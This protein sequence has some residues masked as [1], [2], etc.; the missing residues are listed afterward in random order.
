[1]SE[2]NKWNDCLVS[3]FFPEVDEMLE[4]E[5][6][7]KLESLRKYVP[8]LI[9]MM[10]ELRAKT[11]REAQLNKIQSLHDMITNSNKKLKLET[12]NRC[13]EVLNNIYF[14]VNPQLRLKGLDSPQICPKMNSPKQDIPEIESPSSTP[15]SPSPPP[16]ILRTK[17]VTIPTEKV[18]NDST[19]ASSSFSLKTS[20]LPKVNVY[21]NVVLNN[22]TQLSKP[23]L[24]DMSKPPI[25]LD[26]LKTLEDDVHQKLHDASSE[27]APV[28]GSDTQRRSSLVVPQHSKEKKPISP[29]VRSPVKE[30]K[31][32]KPDKVIKESQ[33]LLGEILS[34][35]DEKILEEK[36]KKNNKQDKRHSIGD[37]KEEEPSSSKPES[38]CEKKDEADKSTVV[39]KRLADK[40]HPKPRQKPSTADADKKSATTFSEKETKAIHTQ[41][42]LENVNSLPNLLQN[43]VS[44]PIPDDPTLRTPNIVNAPLLKPFPEPPMLTSGLLQL[45]SPN[46]LLSSAQSPV[47]NP[48]PRPSPEMVFQPRMDMDFEPRRVDYDQINRFPAGQ[49][50]LP[51]A[52][53]HY[54]LDWGNSYY[55][56]N[57]VI[58]QK[59]YTERQWNESYNRRGLRPGDPRSYKEYKEMKEREARVSI[60]KSKETKDPRVSQRESKESAADTKNPVLSRESISRDPRLARY[61]G[62]SKE[63]YSKDTPA[64]E[65]KPKSTI[66]VSES[67][68]DKMYSST[69]KNKTSKINKK[70]EDAFISPLD[71]L[72]NVGREDKTGRGYGV[73]KFKIPK[74]RRNTKSAKPPLCITIDD[75][76]GEETENVVSTERGNDSDEENDGKEV[77]VSTPATKESKSNTNFDRIVVYVNENKTQSVKNIDDSWVRCS[78]DDSEFVSEYDKEAQQ[79]KESIPMEAEP[80]ESLA[81]ESVPSLPSEIPVENVEAEE[82]PVKEDNVEKED[83]AKKTDSAS[84]NEPPDQKILAHFFENLLKSKNKKEKK[85]ALFS[86]IE[87]FSDSFDEKEIQKIRNIISDPEGTDDFQHKPKDSVK[88]IND[89]VPEVGSTTNDDLSEVAKVVPAEKAATAD[90]A[91]TQVDSSDNHR[92][93][94]AQPG[95]SS[96]ES[97]QES[98][99]ERI[100]N[101][102]RSICGKPKKKLRTEL[103]MLHDDIQEMFIRD[104]VLT[105][106]GKR[107]CRIL[108]DD[109][110]VLGADKPNTRSKSNVKVKPKTTK[111]EVKE[112]VKDV[113]ILINK[114]P[115][116]V[117]NASMRQLRER[118]RTTSYVDSEEDQLDV[119]QQNDVYSDGLGSGEEDGKQEQIETN[120]RCTRKK[121]RRGL[122]ALGIIPKTKHRKS[123]D[124][125][126]QKLDVVETDKSYYFDYDDR[127]KL[128]CKLCNYRSLVLTSHYLKEHPSSEVLCSRLPPEK[129]ES[130][131]SDYALNRGKYM[132]LTKKMS[133]KYNY[134]CRLCNYSTIT[135]P[136]FFYE[137]VTT[138]TGEY[139][140]R[141]NKCI[142]F[143]CS[144]RKTVAAHTASVHPGELKDVTATSCPAAAIF[145]YLCGECNY[146]QLTED[147]V[148][149]HV[150]TF[151]Q[152]SNASI[153]KISM[154]KVLDV[155]LVSSDYKEIDVQSDALPDSNEEKPAYKKPGPK[156]KTMPKVNDTALNKEPD[157]TDKT[158]TPINEAAAETNRNNTKE[159]KEDRESSSERPSKESSP[160]K[161]KSGT[162]SQTSTPSKVC[163]KDD[164]RSEDISKRT[165]S[166]GRMR[167]RST[168][169]VDCQP[170]NADLIEDKLPEDNSTPV[171][172]SKNDETPNRKRRRSLE[173]LIP[174]DGGEDLDSIITLSSRSNR[175]AKEKATAKLKTLMENNDCASA[176]DKSAYSSAVP[177]VIDHE[178]KPIEARRN[179]VSESKASEN[180]KNVAE[181][182]TENADAK[183]PDLNVFTC[184]TDI[185]EE[186]AKLIEKERLR[187]MDELTKSIGSRQSKLDFIDKLCDRLNNEK[188]EDQL[189]DCANVVVKRERVNEPLTPSIEEASTSVSS[190][191]IHIDS[192]KNPCKKPV[193][194]EEILPKSNIEFKQNKSVALFSSTIEKLQGKVNEAAEQEANVQDTSDTVMLTIGDIMKITKKGDSILYSCLVS[195][196]YVSTTDNRIFQL[197]CKFGHP[198]PNYT[199]TMCE[200]CNVPLAATAG[201]TLLENTFDHIMTSHS[202]FIGIQQ[203]SKKAL[204]RMRKLS[205]DKLSIKAEKDPIENMATL[206]IAEENPFPFKIVDVMS[207]AETSESSAANSNPIKPVPP[208]TPISQKQQPAPVQLLVKEAKLTVSELSRPRK[209]QK[210]LAKF[211]ESPGELYKCPH[212][213][214]MFGTNVRTFF[215]RHIKIHEGSGDSM[216]PCVYCDIKTPWEHVPLHIDIRHG[217][218]QYSCRYCMYRAISTE[219]VCIHQHQNHQGQ[220]FMVVQLPQH[221]V[222]KKYSVTDLKF[223][224]KTLCEPFR[225]GCNTS[226]EYLFENEFEKHLTTVHGD[227]IVPCG[228]PG[229]TYRLNSFLILG[230]WST[231]HGLS[232][233]QCGY[234]KTSGKEESKMYTHFVKFHPSLQPH[235]L[236]RNKPVISVNIEIGYSEEAFTRMRHITKLP[237]MSVVLGKKSSCNIKLLKLSSTLQNYS[238]VS[239]QSSSLMLKPIAA[240]PPGQ[241]PPTK[242]LISN[243]NVK[244]LVTSSSEKLYL[245][246]TT[247]INNPKFVTSVAPISKVA[248]ETS[249]ATETIL[250]TLG[251]DSVSAITD[252]CKDDIAEVNVRTEKKTKTSPTENT[253]TDNMT[254]DKG[255]SICDSGPPP[256]IYITDKV[257]PITPVEH[258]VVPEADHANLLPEDLDPLII[259]DSIE[260]AADNFQADSNST[261]EDPL[262]SHIEDPLNVLNALSDPLNMEPTVS[263]AEN[264]ECSDRGLEEKTTHSTFSTSD[265][266]TDSKSKHAG[267]S[268][269]QLYRCA[270]CSQSFSIIPALKHHLSTSTNCKK[271]GLKPYQCFHCSKTVKTPAV[272][273]DH[274]QTHGV[275]RFICSLCN[276]KFTT[277]AAARTHNKSRHSIHHTTLVPLDNSKTDVETDIFVVKPTLLNVTPNKDAEV[278]WENSSGRSRENVF[279]PGQI[280]QIPIRQIFNTNVKCGLCNYQT[281]VR[282]NIVRHLQMHSEEKSVPDT[283]PVNP[284]PCLEKNEK[285]FDKMINL[286]ASSITGRMGVNKTSEKEEDKYP[287]FVPTHSRF[288]CCA[289]GCSYLCPEE[290]N[291]KHHLMALHSDDTNFTCAHCKHAISPTDAESVIKHFKLHGLHLYKCQHCRFIHNLKHKVEKHIVD[292]HLDATVKVVTLRSMESEPLEGRETEES[293]SVTPNKQ[294]PWRCC[295]CKAKYSTKQHIQ[296]HIMHKH[297]VDAQY[298][299]TLCAFKNNE[300]DSFKSHFAES[301]PGHK[302]DIIFVYQKFEEESPKDDNFDTTP[303]WQRDKP[304][305]RHIRGILF[306]ETSPPPSKVSKKTP[307]SSVKAQPCDPIKNLADCIEAV[308]KGT[309]S[310]RNCEIKAEDTHCSIGTEQQ[311]AESDNDIRFDEDDDVKHVKTE[312]PVIVIDSDDSDEEVNP[313]ISSPHKQD[314]LK[315]L[316]SSTPLVAT[317]I[318][319]L[320]CI[321]NIHLAKNYSKEHLISL[322]GNFG[323]AHKKQWRCP[324]C[325]Q[326]KSRRVADFI[327]HIYKDYNA[328]RFK[329]K[330][331][332]ERSITYKYMLDHLRQHPGQSE[333]VIESLPPNIELET[334][335]HMVI[336]EQTLAILNSSPASENTSLAGQGGIKCFFCDDKFP[337][338]GDCCEHMLNHWAVMPYKCN[339]CSV[340]FYNVIQLEEHQ[341]TLHPGVPLSLEPKGPTLQVAIKCYESLNKRLSDTT[342]C[343][344]PSKKLKLEEV[345]VIN[346]DVNAVSKVDLVDNA[347]KIEK[348]DIGDDSSDYQVVACDICPWIGNTNALAIQHLKESH[349]V[350]SG[351]YHV[352]NKKVTTENYICNVCNGS[353]PELEL[354]EH[355]LSEHRDQV[356]APYRY[357]CN[358][359]NKKY[360]MAGRLKVHM[361]VVHGITETK[362]D[363]RF[364]YK[365]T[366]CSFT[367]VGKNNSSIKLHMSGHIPPIMC[368]ICKKRF[369]SEK[370]A[371]NHHR[372]QHPSQEANLKKLE[373]AL[374]E[375]QKAIQLINKNAVRV[376]VSTFNSLDEGKEE[377]ESKSTDTSD[378]NITE[379]VDEAAEIITYDNISE[380]S[381]SKSE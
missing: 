175:A 360:Q 120:T 5:Y 149:R 353:F 53:N 255:T 372:R 281:K 295:M 292:S 346:I 124:K 35:I 81:D 300:A 47:F 17:P 49:M 321:D 215:E 320:E 343:H 165:R 318:P 106:N 329:C 263:L 202:D 238:S 171:P 90:S 212:L 241:R 95:S 67:K 52:Q 42:L 210:A 268:G 350:Y 182:S 119:Q 217:H 94:D 51:Q 246:P 64:Q 381:G 65:S 123:I 348:T 159:I 236:V 84:T 322:F 260:G 283:A 113:R 30:A 271:P 289:S 327:Y 133:G 251:R 358:K 66:P 73:Q 206:E 364:M 41:S 328:Y 299:C 78:N 29:K 252:K 27:I 228:F 240:M 220:E 7:K 85:T 186:D 377:M 207:L 296:T 242:I 2:I 317:K 28:K 183:K 161:K 336:R 114:I 135:M 189:E 256:L 44:K 36:S 75:S 128:P 62:K 262:N 257:S 345:D 56:N 282:V 61:R 142:N 153:F 359:C 58:D 163:K 203:N 69:N 237:A 305:I 13:E 93:Q 378:L 279:L 180:S 25:S 352:I 276:E 326:F 209:A 380:G 177:N 60:D 139:R 155:A 57:P 99:G 339:K 219:Y 367:C 280:E 145:V 4:E 54:P 96:L 216:V 272:L 195:Q 340:E 166:S 370:M 110:I 150:A 310:V 376:N 356:F 200:K 357:K 266:D 245:V 306:D 20:H 349:S 117:M 365:C 82:E 264:S 102:K 23:A 218:C 146:F 369:K 290:A 226:K 197:H 148:S 302:I 158:S 232:T 374:Q 269:L 334:W 277:L 111:E 162:K 293:Q 287:E 273:L 151:H 258:V 224:Y 229:C 275:Q 87:T 71:S 8:F 368:L 86:L 38:Y 274:L 259:D 286:A 132:N 285:M 223:D 83:R 323:S 16:S 312:D 157:P 208:L 185:M 307:K 179:R 325:H 194:D 375:H 192:P 301:H 316:N 24:L 6:N 199:S 196:C 184:K 130:A 126:P 181:D 187:K 342:Y 152:T 3:L 59:M 176:V 127:K 15:A 170:T 63:S 347:I 239:N 76:S 333:D 88:E 291:L 46:S 324:K 74:K 303:L 21:S 243:P 311:N 34:S 344:V 314:T 115:D 154:S 122:W 178:D 129:A 108:R 9:N 211:I 167:V 43:R 361:T 19:S 68:F 116:D 244:F 174:E 18:T 140:H 379:S 14:K 261:I 33:N 297:D 98:V 308:A 371:K 227:S 221:K 92:S 121:S 91:D 235:L 330:I 107:M 315:R 50:Y 164:D 249:S 190:P 48:S 248:A 10:T 313:S 79:S 97:V 40:Y 354:R 288:V 201:S 231:F 1:M 270:V 335:I 253:I 331:C 45:L 205:G 355:F 341:K 70:E 101:R 168:K 254:E 351:K 141:C 267:L 11:N 173:K 134:T 169:S 250:G 225:C 137:H 214:C 363:E 72:Y 160:M 136:V 26:D 131:I 89:D 104:G 337:S 362:S 278:S 105:A 338:M 80:S 22:P 298:K 32:N 55:G 222:V 125:S 77:T 143:Y 233:F 147:N 204:V 234:C 188:N 319:K 265:E 193:L 247:S 100:K 198:Q 144:T 37:A 172:F 103:D 31:S 109:P 309:D 304:R 138:H 284:V 366:L 373:E 39:Y 112:T 191:K 156:S 332:E 230:H 12:L 294:K 213:Y 118:R